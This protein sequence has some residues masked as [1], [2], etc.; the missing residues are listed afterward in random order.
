MM[1]G[2]PT[3]ECFPSLGSK[4]WRSGESARLSSMWPGFKSGVDAICQLSLLSIL[5][6][7]PR[8]FSLST[9]VFHSPQ[10]PTL[11][12]SSST[13]YQVDEESLCG[14]A[15]SKSLFIYIYLFL[16]KYVRNVRFKLVFYAFQTSLVNLE[17]P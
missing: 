4:G 15:T 7:A 17:L 1:Q 9:P 8:G 16:F 10:K 6:F 12:N 13:R 2:H 14:C 11:A 3:T 5:S